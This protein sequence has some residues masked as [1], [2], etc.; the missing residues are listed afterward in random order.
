MT[1][2]EYIKI[3]NF[4]DIPNGEVELP[5]ELQV[6]YAKR[7]LVAYKDKTLY[8]EDIQPHI[9]DDKYHNLSWDGKALYIDGKFCKLW[10]RVKD[11]K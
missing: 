1:K 11:R 3:D 8:W 7:P 10:T 6:R 5:V 9:K 2:E 4:I